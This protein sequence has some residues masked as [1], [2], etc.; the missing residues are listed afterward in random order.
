ML[1][2]FFKPY[3]IPH[4][5]VFLNS[6][7][8][9]SQETYIVSRHSE[10]KRDEYSY[11]WNS[12]GVRSKEFSEKPNVITL[13]CSITFGLGLPENLTWGN[14]LEKKLK[15]VGNYSVGNISYN[16][17]SIMKAISSFFGMIN[18]YEYKPDYVICN[19]PNLERAYFPNPTVDYI[20]D[21]FWYKHDTL[22]KA[23]APFPWS[24]ILPVEWI[25]YSNLD[26]IKMLE[27]FCKINNIKLIWS[28]WSTNISQEMEKFI[29]DNFPSYILDITRVEF[30]SD[31]EYFK[32]A[33]SLDKIHSFFEMKNWNNIRCHELEYNKHKDVFN[34]AYDYQRVK[35]EYLEELNGIHPHPG[36]HRH[37]HWADFYFQQ[38]FK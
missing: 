23:S 6:D 18:K 22:T 32:T 33:D 15:E 35:V 16:G 10:I 17:S 20:G 21:L 36:L 4:D 24:K 12:D 1:Y 31:Y 25:Y 26:Y 14:I 38:M 7:G 8:N 3:V 29:I 19:F 28:T 5:N 27:V 34:F 11:K 37:L 13:G 30:P 2:K 9:Y